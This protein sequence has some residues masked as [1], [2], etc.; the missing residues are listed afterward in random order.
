MLNADAFEW[1]K[2]FYDLETLPMPK[3][4]IVSYDANDI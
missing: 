4:Q 3:L 2:Y 1:S